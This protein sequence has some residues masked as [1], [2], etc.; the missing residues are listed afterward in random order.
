MKI[1]R[2]GHNIYLNETGNQTKKKSWQ[3]T[4]DDNSPLV[5]VNRKTSK[6]PDLLFLVT[7]GRKFLRFFPR[8]AKFPPKKFPQKFIRKKLLR[9]DVCMYV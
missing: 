1:V 9:C 6:Q 2:S 8:S 3:E 5:M 4:G 7:C